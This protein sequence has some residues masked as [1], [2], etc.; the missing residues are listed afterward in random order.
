MLTYDYT[1]I[2]LDLKDVLV[3]NITTNENT[4]S[5]FVEQKREPHICPVCCSVTDK[6]HDYRRQ[7][8]KDMPIQSKRVVLILRKR[9]YLC[10]SCHKHFLEKNLFLARYQR[11]TNRLQQYLISLFAATRSIKSIANE[12]AC[13]ITTASKHFEKVSYPKPQLTPVIAIDEFRGN[14]GGHK[15]QCIVSDPKNRKLL[16][17]LPTRKTEDLYEYFTSFS[18][19]DRLNVQYVVMDLSALFSSV[20]KR[21]FPNAKIV[22]DKFHVCRLANWAMETVRKEEQKKFASCRRIYF[23]KSRWILLT[24][25]HKLNDED[26][27][28]LSN[29][30]T[31][32]ES[33]RKAYCLKEEFYEILSSSS[34]KDMI[35]HW[36]EWQDHVVQA[37]LPSFDR[38]MQTVAKWSKA[39]LAAAQT[40]YSNGFIEGC[41][42][43]TKVLKRVCYGVKN[44]SR[45]RN[46]ILYIANS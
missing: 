13:S 5:I 23:K 6:I 45:F 44:F 19:K 32:S 36:K 38:F 20:V 30:L 21:C 24:R 37:K 25:K 42:N 15:F 40:G 4:I 33:L 17:I 14:A 9:R 12:C 11:M 28:Q 8:I 10:T 43:R 34:S 31:V 18:M 2:L 35:L 29:M 3:T 16:D 1:N 46:R 26:K 7:T 41:N 39:I 27:L 22:S